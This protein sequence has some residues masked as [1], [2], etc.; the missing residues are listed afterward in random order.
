[1]RLTDCTK[2]T[3]ALAAMTLMLIGG[4]DLKPEFDGS[5]EDFLLSQ[6]DRFGTVMQDPA[7]YRVQIIY[8]QIDR[9]ADNNPSFTSYDYRLSDDEYFYPASTVK[10]P[11]AALALEKINALAVDGL[12]RDSTL[13]VG[14]ETEGKSVARYVREVLLVSDNDA[15]N[16]LYDFVGQE[17]ID[18]SMRG[19]G[20][21]GTRIMHRLSIALSVEENRRTGPVRFVNGDTIVYEEEAVDSA[22]DLTA[23][24]PI[25]LGEAEMIDGERHEGPKD[26][27][28][29]NAY[30]LQAQH[31]VVK[32][33]MFPGA[34]EPGQRFGLSEDD[35]AF[36]YRNMSA[37]P[38]ESGIA[39][40]AD[41]EQY[42]D[43]HV[44]FLMFGGDVTEIAENIRIFNKVG[45]AYGFLTDAA[46]VADFERGVE[47]LLAATVYTNANQTFNDDEYEYDEIARPFLRDLGQAI[48]EVELA[49]ERR[50]RP[51]MSRFEGSQ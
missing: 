34:V 28:I 18:A 1:M 19:K 39:D 9:D 8:T 20:F 21:A 11:V 49:R 51:N 47:F 43:G 48:Y 42:P 32:A 41:S 6:P 31:D 46:Y 37:Y 50:N 36:L 13:R 33:L 23:S 16:R 25:P 30:P 45:L 3:A 14:E 40:Y 2:A 4:C 17:A 5:L 27:A 24:E 35:Y 12:T 44:K 10:L 22:V 38:S 29:K 15:F 26:F 7:K